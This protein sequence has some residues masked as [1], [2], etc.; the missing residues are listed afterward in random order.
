MA[1][2]PILDAQ[3]AAESTTRSKAY[4]STCDPRC[5]LE[6]VSLAIFE[7]NQEILMRLRCATTKMLKD[8]RGVDSQ[9]LRG[10]TA[11]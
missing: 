7:M 3:E 1:D 2:M 5:A 4:P 10:P 6:G 9:S 8:F 11:L